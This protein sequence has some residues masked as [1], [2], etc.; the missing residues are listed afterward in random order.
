VLTAG[1]ADF[2][3]SSSREIGTTNYL[4]VLASLQRP[5]ILCVNR[6]YRTVCGG[7]SSQMRSTTTRNDI[8]H[9]CAPPS[10]A[11]ALVVVV[12]RSSLSE[13]CRRSL[14]TP[15]FLCFSSREIG[16]TSHLAV[17]LSAGGLHRSGRSCNSL[18]ETAGCRSDMP[19][20][21]LL[22]AEIGT[23]NYL[24]VLS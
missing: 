19:I 1:H 14:A 3:A 4:T 24:P 11:V 7:H 15:R 10:A 22:A 23:T 6:I 17:L 8:F 18:S 16:T 9:Q 20:S 5:C 13:A 12:V 21:V 2:C